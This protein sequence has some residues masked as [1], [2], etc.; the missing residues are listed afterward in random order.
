MSRR[1]FSAMLCAMNSDH[2]F[3]PIILDHGP[4][5]SKASRVQGLSHAQVMLVQQTLAQAYRTESPIA[6][7]FYTRLFALDPS[8]RLLFQRD[9]REQ[10]R[11]FMA[12]LVSVVSRLAH[13]GRLLPVLNRYARRQAGNG[14][15]EEHYAL[16]E[17][18]LLGALGQVLGEQF[19]PMVETA[20]RRAC[21]LVAELWHEP[22]LNK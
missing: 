16:V 18:A 13:P 19:T 6:E 7:L 22:R 3:D 5:Q 14:V 1:R 21:R 20:W 2:Q 4:G 8:L 10:E 11:K 12:L 9:S 15:R 17:A